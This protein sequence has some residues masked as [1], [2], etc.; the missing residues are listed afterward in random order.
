MR[1]AH[2]FKS[3][4]Y[5]DKSLISALAS[6]AM[7]SDALQTPSGE[8]LTPHDVYRALHI[9]PATLRRWADIGAIESTRTPG[10]HRRYTR[11]ELDRLTA[12]RT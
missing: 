7:S 9:A 2:E 3:L 1:C 11:A 5:L 12:P 10:G 8:L 6:L 4:T